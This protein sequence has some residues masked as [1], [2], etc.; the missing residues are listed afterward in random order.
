LSIF[1]V[2]DPEDGNVSKRLSDQTAVFYV[3]ILL[4]GRLSKQTKWCASIITESL[5]GK[6][7]PAATRETGVLSTRSARRIY[8]RKRTGGNRFSRAL[9]GRLRRD[10]AIVFSCRSRV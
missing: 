1:R 2:D 10:D 4:L 8:K 9:Q 3:L 7:L 5:P 6:Y